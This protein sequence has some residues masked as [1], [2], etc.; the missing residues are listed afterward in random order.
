MEN[1]AEYEALIA[2]IIGIFLCLFGYRLK[3]VAFIVIWFVIGFYLMT[4]A[5]PHI[6]NDPTWQQLLPIGAGIVLGMLGFS[7]EKFCI[8]AVAA[9]TVSTTIIETFQLN[10]IFGIALSIGAGVIVGC[11]AVAFIKPVGIITTALSGAKLIA[12]YA[13]SGLHLAHEPYFITILIAC[14]A[15]GILFQFKNCKHIE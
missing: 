3:K 13:I 15:I 2:I 9:F 12:K 10:D 6:T 4:L 11:I 5:A 1:I 8:F 7:I 14:C